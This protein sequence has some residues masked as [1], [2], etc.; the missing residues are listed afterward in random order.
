[1]GQGQAVGHPAWWALGVP[2]GSSEKHAEER[3]VRGT[4]EGATW[5]PGP[6]SR[7]T[8]SDTQPRAGLAQASASGAAGRTVQSSH[9][10]QG[11]GQPPGYNSRGPEFLETPSPAFQCGVPGH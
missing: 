6:Q 9:R 8:A 11:G 5:P 2:S 3:E 7:L 4:E 10:Y 1:M